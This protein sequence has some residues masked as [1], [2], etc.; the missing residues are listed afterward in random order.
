[1]GNAPSVCD[2]QAALQADFQG[3]LIYKFCLPGSSYAA[4]GH[5]VRRLWIVARRAP[6]TL[7]ALLRFSPGALGGDGARRLLLWQALRALAAAHAAGL[8]RAGDIRPDHVLVSGSGRL[9]SYDY[10]LHLN[11]LAG[12]R[13]GDPC[14]H[15]ILPWVLD[16]SQPPEPA[17][18]SAPKAGEHVAGWRDLGRTKWR[19]AK[20]DQQLDFTFSS[21]ERPHHVSGEAL[22]ELALC[23]YKARRLPV[24]ELQRVVRAAFQPREYPAS[25]AR[26]VA[27]TPDEAIPEF[28][29]DPAVFTSHHAQMA[30]LAVPAWAAGPADFVARHRAALESARASAA[31][32]L[33]IDLT[34]GHQLAGAAAVAAKNRWAGPG[35][36]PAHTACPFV[37]DVAAFG[38]LA[39]QV[40]ER[41]LVLDPP[42]G[43]LQAWRA[44]VARLPPAAAALAAACLAPGEGRPLAAAL[45]RCDY[46]SQHGSAAGGGDEGLSGFQA[47]LAAALA[48]PDRRVARERILPLAARLIAAGCGGARSST[49]AAAALLRPPA[50]PAMVKAAGAAP[51]LTSVLPAVLDAL[52]GGPPPLAQAAAEAMV[53]LAGALPRPAALQALLRPLLARLAGPPDV[54]LALIALGSALGY[55]DLVYLL[56]P[57]AAEA[58][59]LGP[60]HGIVPT[61]PEVE[62]TLA[63]RY[64]WSAAAAPGPR[65][66]A[67][68]ERAAA[69]AL[70]DRA[71]RVSPAAAYGTLRLGPW[72]AAGE[73]RRAEATT[74]RL[75][76]GLG[77]SSPSVTTWDLQSAAEP[78]LGKPGRT[79]T[80]N[81]PF[82][83]FDLGSSPRA[84]N[85]HDW[86]WLPASGGDDPGEWGDVRVWGDP[87]SSGL[88][89]GGAGTP[90][91][92]WRLRAAAVH[93]WR[94]HREGMAA[95]TALPGEGGFVTVGAG[96]GA[97][98]LRVWDLASCSA[99]AQYR[100]HQ[101][102]VTGLAV[103]PGPAQLVAS[104]DAAGAL[105]LWSAANG[106]LA[107]R[108]AEPSVLSGA[109]P[110]GTGWGLQSAANGVSPAA[111]A[112]AA[113]LSTGEAAAAGQGFDSGFLCVAAAERNGCD[114]LLAGAGG[115]RL[116]WVDPEQGTLAA[117]VV[118]ARRGQLQEAA[119]VTCIGFAAEE[120]GGGSPG[121]GAVA[122]AGLASG[123]A[124][125][126]DARVG[127]VAALWRVHGGTV[128][129]VCCQ[130]TSALLTGSQ[131][132]ALKL[133]DLR[134]LGGPDGAK[135]SPAP[136]H[137]FAPFKAPVGGAALLGGDAIAWGAGADRP[138][139]VLS[140]APPYGEAATQVRLD[141]GV[142]PGLGWSAS[143]G[144]VTGGS[145]SA[146]LVGAAIL[147][148]SRL[149]LLGTSDGYVRVCC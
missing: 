57:E 136:L 79:S 143:G 70:A 128:S 51:F 19:L 126:A 90:E 1:M 39:V 80:G 82:P 127:D 32:H 149:L 148:L 62:K 100:G 41:R 84:G 120:G 107:R 34:F 60:L 5:A 101:A 42:A 114:W 10:L 38:Q 104:V 122:A 97:D 53:P 49:R 27:W 77:W 72:E 108:F 74:A 4:G 30:D 139:A 98:V 113:A 6:Y 45:L 56:Y 14:F 115:A 37:A 105:H 95:L 144:T 12:R 46:F 99:G 119:Q 103:L 26:L 47:L 55:W 29:S 11:R 28:F 88:G 64:G 52:C 81:E 67:A 16:M 89:S 123:H 112:A 110:P 40:E 137:A 121:S 138:L 71:A 125:L 142:A 2:V 69:A 117:D 25:V 21:A 63:A 145:P 91:R 85:K 36:G 116:R 31:I 78:A 48:C 35:L 18:H 76:E 50:L 61:W 9:S 96:R 22:S 20:G 59:G 24:A 8:S 58:V 130:G 15:P 109:G 133:W 102:A 132:G 131:E 17:M 124:A 129:A 134:K 106:V 140:L 68:A 23:I 75:I 7:G 86:A 118:L 73:A 66:P 87:Y 147:P 83:G 33:W 111:S 135:G 54:A 94:A 141:G 44:R 13:W 93:G 65:L 146:V 3:Q 43:D 92:P